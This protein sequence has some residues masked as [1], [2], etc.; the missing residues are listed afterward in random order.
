VNERY[1]R[2]VTNITKNDEFPWLN[3]F[4]D[5][6]EWAVQATDHFGLVLT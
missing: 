1:A 4:G 5:Y 2:Y 3:V 6:E